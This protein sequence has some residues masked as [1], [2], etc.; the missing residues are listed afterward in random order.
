[1][2]VIIEEDEES[3]QKR[4]AT[5]NEGDAHDDESAISRSSSAEANTIISDS[6]TEIQD[7]SEAPNID[8]TE[9]NQRSYHV[10]AAHTTTTGVVDAIRAP[11]PPSSNVGMSSAARARRD[12]GM[13]LKTS[14]R[15]SARQSGVGAFHVLPESDEETKEQEV[16]E[17]GTTDHAINFE[18]TISAWQ[19]EDDALIY[20]VATPVLDQDTKGNDDT[21]LT[22]EHSASSLILH[23][24]PVIKDKNKKKKIGVAVLILLISVIVATAATTARNRP[25]SSLDNAFTS[26]PTPSPTVNSDE[27]QS[28]LE[29]FS[30]VED[31]EWIGSPQRNALLWLANRDRS[32]IKFT[33]VLLYQRYAVIVL[34]YATQPNIL[35]FLDIW[36]DETKHECDWGA[37]ISCI[38]D[39]TGIRHLTNIDLSKKRLQGTLPTEV[40]LLQTLESLHISEND[41]GGTIPQEIVKLTVLTSLD[42]SMNNLSGTIPDTVG[43]IEGLSILK[44]RRNEFNGTLPD[45][46]KALPDLNYNNLSG[47]F[48]SF[49]GTSLVRR[50]ELSISHNQFSGELPI[51]NAL[52]PNT[53][54]TSLLGQLRIKYFDTS[55][56]KLRGT[57]FP[58]VEYMDK[59]EVLAIGGSS[60]GTIPSKIANLS[61]LRYFDAS[62]CDLSGTL[63]G[64][65]GSL[66]LL[67]SL[68]VEFGNLELM[69]ALYLGDNAFTSTIPVALKSMRSLRVLSLENNEL[70][71]SIPT[72]ISELYDLVELQLSGNT[73][74]G[75]VPEGVCALGLEQLLVDRSGMAAIVMTIEYQIKS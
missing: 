28:Y 31:L 67:G 15:T 60:A 4:E 6:A 54:V 27:L 59:L 73:L 9:S 61:L 56:N 24:T 40:G 57:V 23:A 50:E 21:K 65:I 49:D 13:K 63:P 14:L 36:V 75:L 62:N 1:M 55:N 25:R 33:D 64:A 66:P 43:S 5:D 30:S 41:V 42:L 46:L 47:T 74:E 35:S 58:T 45:I 7:E 68:P 52:L 2:Q 51:S 8:N 22:G 34:Y 53:D 11:D 3:Q 72:Q 71:G 10:D 19:D 17:I 26:S 37:V 69:S 32:G 20:A 18:R 29:A 39:T 48:P 70:S 38:T 12:M 16:E 44:L